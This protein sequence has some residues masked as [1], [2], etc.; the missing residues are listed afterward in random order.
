M[1]RTFL[2]PVKVFICGRYGAG[3]RLTRPGGKVRELLCPYRLGVRSDLTS[4]GVIQSRPRDRHAGR[5]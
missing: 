3:F 4:P 2:A 1:P 5:G